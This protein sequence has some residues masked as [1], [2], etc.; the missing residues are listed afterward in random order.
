[1]LALAPLGVATVGAASIGSAAISPAR[2]SVPQAA[3][4]H[5]SL[6]VA[7]PGF[8]GFTAVT[9]TS[10]TSAWAFET[11]SGKVP[12]AYR[13][14]GSSWARHALPASRGDFVAAASSSSA[15]NVWAFTFDG[16]VLRYN[17]RGWTKVRKFGKAI[18]SGL[19]LG[20]SN[21][22]IFGPPGTWHFNGHRWKHLTSVK[23]LQ[24]ASALSASS[25]WAYGG[26]SVAHWNGRSWKKTSVAKLLPKN[27][28]LSRSFVAGIY[29]ASAR[30]VY[31]IASGGREDEGGPLVLLH[32]NGSA[33]SRVAMNT[34][35]GGP[36]GVAADG[37][38]GLWIPVVT[39]AP[40]SGSMEHF[41]GGK[42]SGAALP[43]SPPH[44]FLFGAA[45]A[46]RAAAALAV[47][48]TR[49]SLNAS[50]TTAVILR[51]G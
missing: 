2:A 33:W 40:G 12:A 3:G 24:G 22:W 51:F 50:T 25:I 45:A 35:L 48:F 38:G 36:V 6:K 39:G 30:S 5:V 15:G 10:G 21:A 44:L 18:N 9:A 27:T 29:A 37:K 47:G 43:V 32:Y 19:T 13:F 20:P 26:T 31:A 7:G 1:M 14:N 49:K 41:S 34:K 16:L 42:L 8:P 17:G 4:W 28:Q 46:K 23:G 11:Q